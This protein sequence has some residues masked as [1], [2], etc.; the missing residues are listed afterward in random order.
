LLIIKLE[1]LLYF[2]KKIF[3][4]ILINFFYKLGKTGEDFRK[5]VFI[6]YSNSSK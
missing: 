6:V 4:I 3:N 5:L 2:F 1:K